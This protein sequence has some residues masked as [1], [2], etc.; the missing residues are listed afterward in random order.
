VLRT[1]RYPTVPAMKWLPPLTATLMA[2]TTLRALG[3]MGIARSHWSAPMPRMSSCYSQQRRF[4]APASL[5]PASYVT[6]SGLCRA[7]HLTLVHM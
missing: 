2:T 1:P 3:P 5:I 4:L 7:M 6:L